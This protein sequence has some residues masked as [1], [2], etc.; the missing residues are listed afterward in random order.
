MGAM[1]F[2]TAQAITALVSP[3][4]GRVL[5]VAAGHGLFGILLAQKNPGVRVTALDWPKVVEVAKRNADR[6]GV[7]D[8]YA[9]ITGDA[10]K[11]EL[12][13]PYDLILLTNLLHHF[14]AEQCT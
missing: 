13:G 4:S 10:F 5:D 3:V 12:Q 9:T 14:S 6:M 1:M 8:R 11:V 2:P 7:G